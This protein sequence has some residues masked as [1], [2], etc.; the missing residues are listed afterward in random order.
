[1]DGYSSQHLTGRL[2]VAGRH[3]TAYLADLLTRRGYSFNR[4]V[5]SWRAVQHEVADCRVSLLA[6]LHH[7]LPRARTSHCSCCCCSCGRPPSNA[8][9][10]VLAHEHCLAGLMPQVGRFRHGAADQGAAVLHVLRPG[11]GGQGAHNG[12]VES[13]HARSWL[14]DSTV[15][16]LEAVRGRS[17]RASGSWLQLPRKLLAACCCCS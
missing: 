14:A 6:C 7:L 5:Q 4:C 15:L 16:G 10:P 13:A 1:M 17:G 9:P 12:S 3:I 8:C 2:N 11:T